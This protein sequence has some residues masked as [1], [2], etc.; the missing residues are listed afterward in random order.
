MSYVVDTNI[1][2][3]LLDGSINVTSL[4]KDGQFLVTHI[5]LD[6]INNTKDS[7]RRAQLF[8]MFSKLRPEIVPTESFVWDV[9]RW[10]NGK[11][12][13]GVLFKKLKQELDTMNKSKLNNVQDVLITEVVIVNGF[14][15]LTSDRSLAEVVERQGWKSYLL[16][17]NLISR[18]RE[19]CEIEPCSVPER[20][21]SALPSAQNYP[22]W[23]T[24]SYSNLS[25]PKSNS[26]HITT[27]SP[28]G[29]FV[30]MAIIVF[31]FP[32]SINLM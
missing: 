13:D 20:K 30:I 9:S 31:Y 23:G 7:E 22:R 12:S 14:T 1:F 21:Q 2:N 11:F 27:Y 10:D 15:L 4:H 6:E 5:Q 16:Q 26:S 25:C 32:R 19:R 8:L 24:C 3:K 18:S 29:K 28:V 17:N